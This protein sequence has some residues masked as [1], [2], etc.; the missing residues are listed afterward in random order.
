ML[1]IRDDVDLK[2]LEEFGFKADE[3]DLFYEYHAKN[4]GK[5]II[6][7]NVRNKRL[8]FYQNYNDKSY[9]VLYNLIQ[10]GLVEKG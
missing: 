10:A 7:I 6:M 5:D 4:N 8:R 3:Y 2:K 9:D 1:K